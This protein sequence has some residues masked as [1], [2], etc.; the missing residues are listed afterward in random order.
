MIVI[1]ELSILL[2][3]HRTGQTTPT[4]IPWYTAATR[5][6]KQRPHVSFKVQV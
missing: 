3:G 6:R 1:T 5:P 4:L 2:R